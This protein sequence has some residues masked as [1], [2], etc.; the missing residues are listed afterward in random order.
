MAAKGLGVEDLLSLHE[1]LGRR[2]TGRGPADR[3]LA[4]HTWTTAAMSGAGYSAVVRRQ[5]WGL[6]G[7]PAG[8]CG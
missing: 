2:R 4:S 3:V 6:Q 8:E 5:R 1:T 7:L